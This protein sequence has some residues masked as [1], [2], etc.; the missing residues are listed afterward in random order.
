MSLTRLGTYQTRT[1]PQQRGLSSAVRALQQH[2]FSGFY[3]QTGAR[4]SRKPAQQSHYVTELNYRHPVTVPASTAY[5]DHVARRRILFSFL[6]LALLANACGSQDTEDLATTDTV[7]PTTLVETRPTLVEENAPDWVGE[8]V[9]LHDLKAGDCFNQYSWATEDR[10]IELSTKVP[11]QAPHQFEIY[12]LVQHPA[13]NGAPWPGDEEMV[14]FAISQCYESF[15][16][17][18]GL[19]YELSELELDYLT[20]NRSNFEHEIAQFR[21]VHCY[22]Y[23]DQGGEL[24]GSSRGS[25]R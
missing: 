19:I 23:L 18:V 21:G 25:Q 2:R 3:R 9:N 11:C 4:Q 22:L 20:P 17:F 12:K 16:G 15:E 24:I 6:A 10:Q 7:A 13:R 1:Q 14:A 8:P 5:P